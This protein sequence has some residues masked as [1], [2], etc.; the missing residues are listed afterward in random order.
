MNNVYHPLYQTIYDDIIKQIKNNQLEPGDK[1]PTEFEMID[2]Y[3][4]SRIT[5]SRALQELARNGFIIRYRS[6]GSFVSEQKPKTSSYTTNSF[7]TSNNLAFVMPVSNGTIPQMLFAMQHAAQKKNYVLSIFNSEKSLKK[8]RDILNQLADMPLAGIICYPIESYD[9][10][11]YY[12]PFIIRGTP[13]VAMDKTIPYKE[14]PCIKSDNYGC[15]YK[16]AQYLISK[17]HTRIAFYSHNLKDENEKRR[18]EGYLNALINNGISP[19]ADYFLEIDKDSNPQNM[20][21]E[22]NS[23]IHNI[24]HEQLKKLM[25]LENRPTALFCAFDL[26]AAYVQQQAAKLGISIPED[27]SVVGFDNLPLCEHLQIPLT[28]VTQDF[29]A[30]GNK[31]IDL[32]SRQISGEPVDPSYSFDG[33]VIERNSV[34]TLITE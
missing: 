24:I 6:K 15:A 23:E 22:N 16:M 14:V 1:L 8:E 11:S 12:S 17:G 32:I 29:K 30:M 2:H 19:C 21:A 7:P 18:F 27:L 26:I 3:G 9:N 34:K 28:S 13:L 4:V 33:N 31:A 20:M 5:V 10:V 25:S